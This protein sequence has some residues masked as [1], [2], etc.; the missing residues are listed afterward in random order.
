MVQGRRIVITSWGSYGDVFPYVGIARVLAQRG[1]RPVLAMPE[2]YRTVIETQG[3]EFSPGGR[4][5]DPNDQATVAR[6]MDPRRGTEVILRDLLMPPL[7]DSYEQ[8]KAAAIG[9]D[10][11][12]RHPVTFAAPVLTDKMS[13][14]WVCTV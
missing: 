1:H 5:V 14:Q 9:A 2:F 8:L 6:I 12:G 3:L 13:L 4:D 11:L 10:L 7:R